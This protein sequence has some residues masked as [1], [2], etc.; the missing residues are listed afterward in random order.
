MLLQGCELGIVHENL[1]VTGFAEIHLRRPERRRMDTVV[2]RPGHVGEGGAEQRSADAVTY[3]VGI[4]H[5]GRPFDG[6]QCLEYPFVHVVFE[7][8]LRQLAVGIDPRDDEHGVTLDDQPLDEGILGP[9]VQDV[10][11][12][13]PGRKDQ[14]RTLVDLRGCRRVLQQLEQFAAEHHLARRQC[15]VLADCEGVGTL[16]DRK[17]SVAALQIGQQIVEP[18]HQIFSVGLHCGAQN[19]GI[20]QDKIG[21]RQGVRKLLGI[22][23]GA[24]PRC[25][26][27]AVD[28][29]DSALQP[30]RREQVGLLDEIEDQVLLPVLVAESLVAGFGRRDRLRRAAEHALCCCFPQAHRVAPK[31]KLR[32]DQ[33]RRIGGHSA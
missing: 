4:A 23:L 17:L 16:T 20:G 27:E 21:R 30:V 33:R 3:D 31:L 18:A 2:A 22:E 24:P 32:V 1:Q 11:L 7:G 10:E 12:V 26:I 8:F 15:D 9:Q 6:V 29:G 13:D 25:R 14:Q 19:F 5:A 28:T